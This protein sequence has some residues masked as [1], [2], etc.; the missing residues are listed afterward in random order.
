MENLATGSASETQSYKD[1]VLMSW[2]PSVSIWQIHRDRDAL[3]SG[4]R[5][6]DILAMSRRMLWP[7]QDC[8]PLVSTPCFLQ[9]ENHDPGFCNMKIMTLGW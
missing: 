1:H 3:C 6:S 7:Q 2:V 5:A 9:R 4:R 8:K